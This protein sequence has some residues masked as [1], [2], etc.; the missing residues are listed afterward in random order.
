MNAPPFIDAGQVGA[1][2]D[3][4]SLMRALRE[5]FL[6]PPVAPERLSL[7]IPGTEGGGPGSLLVMPAVRGGGLAVVKL[8]TVHPHLG[9]RPG[10]AVRAVVLALDADTGETRALIDGHSLTLART[11]AA[12]VLAATVLAR[13]DSR[14]LLLV[15]AGA[16][17]GALARA[18]ATTFALGSV[19]VWARRPEA[20]AALAR[21]LEREGLPALPAA[22]ALDAAAAEA[23]IV[24]AATLSETPLVR[25]EA[26]RPGAH[27]DLVGGF[28][29]AMREADDALM[30]RA[31]VWADTPAAL[32]EAGDLVQPLRSGALRH[33]DVRLLADALRAP[34]HRPA[35]AVTVFK[36]V[37][38]ALEDLAAAEL[39][40][41]RLPS[42][43]AAA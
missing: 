34:P 31:A 13:A 32:A 18:Y 16:V 7:E 37:G 6:A 21:E 9:A 5:A 11:A 23:D 29:P 10:G 12:S 4:P 24:S 25:G 27:V 8:V 28:R 1:A 14:R 40:L 2:L 19:T 41:S 36:S 39:L 33:A 26:V 38:C 42:V 20:A 3:T 22:G 35:E 30:S 17:A 43:G 15:G